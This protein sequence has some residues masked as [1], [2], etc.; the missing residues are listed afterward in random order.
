M[1]TRC[2][3]GI[4]FFCRHLFLENFK[5]TQELPEKWKNLRKI[6]FTVKHEVAPLQSNEVAVIRRKCVWFEV[7]AF[8]HGVRGCKR[9][10]MSAHTVVKTC[11]VIPLTFCSALYMT[12]SSLFHCV[13]FI[14]MVKRIC[15]K[16]Q[17]IFSSSGQAARVQR[18]FSP[19]TDLQNEPRGAIPT[20]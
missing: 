5:Q 7:C 18:K 6:A 1:Q 19:G 9:S 2:K 16:R 20:H 14:N 17:P 4:I 8:M 11:Y 10:R 15:R 13:R 3:H 12:E